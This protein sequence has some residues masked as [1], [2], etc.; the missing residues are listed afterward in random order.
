MAVSEK[1][2]DRLG[3]GTQT[4]SCVLSNAPSPAIS[5][6]WGLGFPRDLTPWKSRPGATS[7]E[8]AWAK[9]TASCILGKT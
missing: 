7:L 8:V 2:D 3:V 1:S 6:P 4:F 9:R 5:V